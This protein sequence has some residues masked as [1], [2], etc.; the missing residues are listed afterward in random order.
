M[1]DIYGLS[2]MDEV[3]PALRSL[4]GADKAERAARVL[5]PEEAASFANWARVPA[6]TETPWLAALSG[7]DGL[8][9]FEPPAR[10]DSAWILHAMY[11]DPRRAGA[12][13]GADTAIDTEGANDCDDETDWAAH[14]GPDWQRL[15]WSE[16]AERIGDAIVEEGSYPDRYQLRS[17]HSKNHGWPDN[18]LWSNEGSLDWETW[19]RLIDLLIG[20]SPD[21]P[22][23]RYLVHFC[24][25]GPVL[26]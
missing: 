9:G 15:R 20:H 14:P 8:L 17:W 6:E 26:V 22:D 7:D 23:T 21:G 1:Q 16:L 10:P 24:R 25:N 18:I 3:P 13:S 12:P 5:T 19:H 11:E 4:L 2:D